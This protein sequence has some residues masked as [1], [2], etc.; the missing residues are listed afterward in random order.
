M[1]SFYEPVPALSDLT[2]RL[3]EF[4]PRKKRQQK[5]RFYRGDESVDFVMERG[6]EEPIN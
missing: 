4:L 2:E 3:H 1:I 5:V 6:Y